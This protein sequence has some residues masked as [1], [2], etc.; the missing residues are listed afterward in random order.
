MYTASV[1]L[2]GQQTSRPIFIHKKDEKE[3]PDSITPVHMETTANRFELQLCVSQLLQRGGYCRVGLS[4]DMW[5]FILQSY[6]YIYAC[7]CPSLN[8][9]VLLK[10]ARLFDLECV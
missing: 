9:C 7:H 10:T 1:R 6:M 5:W 8:T 2:A 3:T 4:W